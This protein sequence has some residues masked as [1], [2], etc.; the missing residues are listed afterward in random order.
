ME[1]WTQFYAT[2]AAAA[3]ALLGL[4]FVVVSVNVSAA[5]GPEEA[6]SRRLTE[7]AFQ[8]YLAVLLVA[9]LALFPGIRPTTFGMVTLIATAS[10]SAWVVIRF[11]QTLSQQVEQRSWMYS[12][13]RHVSS[14]VGF[15]ILLVS[16]FR[17][18]V[19]WGDAYNWFAASTLVLLFSATTVSW[20][21][22]RRM[23]GRPSK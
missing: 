22:L 4:L 15:G 2:I 14:L 20:E 7:Q 19:N 13:R 16:A 10:W 18:A 21:L 6:I 11:C 5:L 3:A 12:L 23:A 9:L 8:N 17:M 1:H